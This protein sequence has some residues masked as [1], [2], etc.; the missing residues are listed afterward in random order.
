[1]KPAGVGAT[2]PIRHC[3]NGVL[4]MLIE[5]R[6]KTP[7]VAASAFIAPTAHLI[8]DVE[9]EDE[10]NI[11]FGAVLRADNGTIRIGPRASVQ[12]NAVIHAHENSV[13]SV[14]ADA[15]IGH[16]AVLENCVVENGALVGSNAVVLEGAR[17]KEHAVVSAGSVVTV[18]SEIEPCVLAVGSPATTRRHLGEA[19]AAAFSEHTA[20]EHLAMSRDYLRDGIGMPVHHQ[21]RS[22][23]RR[24]PQTVKA[25]PAV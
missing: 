17:V 8:G 23:H 7:R 25:K 5:Y 19:E 11:W 2:G 4:P 16:C 21:V 10:A 22:T 13:T 15:T 20:H 6:G 14:G 1:M 18:G 3:E 24:P 9:V 12:D